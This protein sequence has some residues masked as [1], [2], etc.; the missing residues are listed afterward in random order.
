MPKHVTLTGMMGSG[1]SSVAPILAATLGRSYV[2]VDALV[3]RREKMTVNEIF[4]EKGEA[5]FRKTEREIILERLDDA[6]AILSL[7]GGAFVWRDTREMLLEKTAVF[8][9][10]ATLETL[11][12]RLEPEVHKRPLL[13]IPGI[14]M[15]YTI[16]QL[17][18]KRVACYEEAHVRIATDELSSQQI[19]Q[20]IL[21]H[22]AL[23]D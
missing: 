11:V 1:K 8:Y 9:L 13:S 23:F 22:R 19:A 10:S 4:N 5:Y 12:R 21:Q 2:E 17:L 20:E 3:E 7:G 14:D 18:L 16:S 6:P 15:Q